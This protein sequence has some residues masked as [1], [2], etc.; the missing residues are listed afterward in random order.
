[1]ISHSPEDQGLLEEMLTTTSGSRMWGNSTSSCWLT[2]SGFAL[3]EL[4]SCP[5]QPHMCSALQICNK[6]EGGFLSGPTLEGLMPPPFS[7]VAG[8][9]KQ[10]WA[11]C[12][13]I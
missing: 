9:G 10:N 5:S 2:P 1:M 7:G 12:E 8:E 13:N 3:E 4:E 6:I 11:A